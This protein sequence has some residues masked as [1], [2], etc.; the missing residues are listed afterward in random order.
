MLDKIPSEITAKIVALVDKSDL[1]NLRLVSRC[2]SQETWQ[3]FGSAFF[4]TIYFDFCIGS[5]ARLHKIAQHDGLRLFVRELR[6][7]DPGFCND[8]GCQALRI[9]HRLGQGYNWTR[10][11]SGCID[12][13][14][15]E[16]VA[17]FRTTLAECLQNCRA[18]RMR[19]GMNERPGERGSDTLL[20]MIDAM[21]ILLFAVSELPIISLRF[22]SIA[23]LGIQPQEL[24]CRVIESPGSLALWTNTLTELRLDWEIFSGQDDVVH[25]AASLITSA[26]ALRRLHLNL[27]SCNGTAILSRLIE[28]PEVSPLTHLVLK[29]FHTQEWQ[30]SSYLRRFK[31]TLLYL[32][33]S[34]IKLDSGEW[35]TVLSECRHSL[36]R[37]EHFTLCHA[38][39]M[40]SQKLA[41][42]YFEYILEWT[43]GPVSGRAQFIVKPVRIPRG[44]WSFRI[45]GIRYE[46]QCNDVGKL[47]TGLEESAR[48]NSQNQGNGAAG[49]AGWRLEDLPMTLVIAGRFK[50]DRFQAKQFLDPIFDRPSDRKP[51]HDWPQSQ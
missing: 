9:E 41:V 7:G 30:L 22:E 34:S 51:R 19:Q 46:G 36:L 8:D 16:M 20:S 6:V 17:S 18:I 43:G 44:D 10:E 24:P 39:Y 50:A 15:S 4:G 45:A 47:L 25:I 49:A 42:L 32:H 38:R 13:A 5:Y 1:L 40:R 35:A 31:D 26:N 21:H 48:E 2:L 14:A 37:L 11:P 27:H 12:T 33:M 28:A 23:G 29:H 3:T